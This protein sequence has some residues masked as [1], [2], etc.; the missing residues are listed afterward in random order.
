MAMASRSSATP[1]F[2]PNANG[3]VHVDWSFP[4]DD[5]H[6]GDRP[7][8][9]H[10]IV[11]FPPPSLCEANPFRLDLSTLRP[12]ITDPLPRSESRPW[13]D[14]LRGGLL[15]DIDDTLTTEGKLTAAAYT[16]LDMLVVRGLASAKV[17]PM[18]E[19]ARQ[20]APRS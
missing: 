15:F 7:E 17:E 3:K 12:Y 4:Y 18:C 8:Y 6:R 5:A 13:D 1:M 20:A 11:T 2:Q 14:Y 10:H 16:A 9:S 19:L